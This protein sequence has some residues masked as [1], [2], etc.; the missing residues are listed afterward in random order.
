MLGFDKA[1]EQHDNEEKPYFVSEKDFKH[2]HC[3][4][5]GNICN[6]KMCNDCYNKAVGEKAISYIAQSKEIF[7]DY[8]KY[9][10]EKYDYSKTLEQLDGIRQQFINEDGTHFE[11]WY[12]SQKK[13]E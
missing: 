13:G 11:D 4:I 8:W 6:Y 2:E 1:Q 12:L 9:S 3:A 10:N 7:D 5:C